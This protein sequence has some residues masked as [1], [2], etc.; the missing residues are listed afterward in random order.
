MLLALSLHPSTFTSAPGLNLLV[1]QFLTEK[2][3]AHVIVLNLAT[4]GISPFLLGLPTCPSWLR[5]FLVLAQKFLCSGY[6]LRPGK[7][8]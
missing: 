8:W 7:S 1:S 2:L 4:Q 3:I 5:N 6:P